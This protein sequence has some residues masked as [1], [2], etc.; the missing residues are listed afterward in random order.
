MQLICF[1]KLL[2][3]LSTLTCSEVRCRAVKCNT[4]QIRTVKSRAVHYIV[5]QCKGVLQGCPSLD[6]CLGRA[7]QGRPGRGAL[8][9]VW[10]GQGRAGRGALTFVC[11][12]S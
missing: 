4:M 10:S 2:N 3:E 1:E 7:G 5:L 6:L 8:T 9:F 11:S 12:G